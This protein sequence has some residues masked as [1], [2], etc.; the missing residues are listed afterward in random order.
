[1]RVE[2]LVKLHKSEPFRPFRIHLADGRDLDIAHPEFL[3]YTPTGRTAVV[4]R[5]DETFEVWK[6]ACKRGPH[7]R[8]K[9]THL[10]QV[11]PPFRG[12]K[13]PAL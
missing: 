9:R 10:G 8:L 3:A 11:N 1:M 12:R 6:S 4:M 7:R 13:A 5:T 2:Q